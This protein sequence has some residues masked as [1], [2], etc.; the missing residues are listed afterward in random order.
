MVGLR[1]AEDFRKEFGALVKPLPLPSAELYSV[2]K[3]R[4]VVATLSGDVSPTAD[5][6]W[7]EKRAL[8]SLA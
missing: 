3:I 5:V 4:R 6:A 2:A 8:E 1:S 7:H